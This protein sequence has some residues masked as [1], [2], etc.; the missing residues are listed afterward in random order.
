MPDLANLDSIE[1]NLDHFIAIELENIWN[2]PEDLVQQ[3]KRDLLEE[4]EDHIEIMSWVAV[5]AL[6]MQGLQF[7]YEQRIDA[8][9]RAP[10]FYTLEEM[11]YR[12][13]HT[14]TITAPANR[15]NDVAVLIDADTG[16][17]LRFLNETEVAEHVARI[18]SK[19]K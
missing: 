4:Y 3:V 15:N 17:P 16:A 6:F 14:T 1:N 19:G 11:M 8:L 12:Y 7:A 9:H 2:V 10:V 18:N 13:P 5:G